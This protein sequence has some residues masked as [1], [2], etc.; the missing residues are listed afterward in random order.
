MDFCLNRWLLLLLPDGWTRTF[1][2]R[3]TTPLLVVVVVLACCYCWLLILGSPFI[4]CIDL[5]TPAVI[6]VDAVIIDFPQLLRTTHQNITPLLLF[7]PPRLFPGIIV[8]DVG[9]VVVLLWRWS[10]LFIVV[11]VIYP[12]PLLPRLLRPRLMPLPFCRLLLLL[13]CL[14]SPRCS[15]IWWD[16]RLTDGPS[17]LPIVWWFPIYL[18]PHWWCQTLCIACRWWTPLFTALAWLLD[19]WRYPFFPGPCWPA[20]IVTE[21]TDPSCWLR[22]RQRLMPIVIVVGTLPAIYSCWLTPLPTTCLFCWPYLPDFNLFVIPD[23]FIWPAP[24]HFLTL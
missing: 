13:L 21:P 2:S 12:F 11:V 19:D 22:Q 24:P 14:C 5:R 20:V 9:V 4:C 6:V 7:P 23:W 17:L 8:V 18:V 3:W 16:W 10:P 15:I 1:P